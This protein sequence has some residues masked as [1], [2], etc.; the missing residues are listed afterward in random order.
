MAS[1]GGLYV[2]VLHLP[3]SLRL[4]VGAL[5][6]VELPAGTLLYAGSARRGLAARIARHCRRRKPRRWHLDWL[7]TARGVAVVGALPLPGS[8]WT[9]CGLNRR[10]GRLPGASTPVPGFGASDCRAGC[11]A[12]LWRVPGSWDVDALA[13]RLGVRAPGSAPCS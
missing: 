10:L 2:L 12:H 11:P 4:R 9:E 13:R 6:P 5:G 3:R 7:T 8:P 1:S